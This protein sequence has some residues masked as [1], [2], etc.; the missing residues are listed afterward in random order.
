M[1]NELLRLKLKQRLNKL[2]SND[3]TNLECWQDAELL[4]KAAL[5]W[6]RRQLHGANA[7]GEGDEGSKR[8]I[9]DLQVLLVEKQLNFSNKDLYFE[10]ETIPD[11]YL[12]FKRIS[13]TAITNKCQ[14]P[15]KIRVTL[16][17]EADIDYILSDV[18][19]KPSF[20]WR[21]TVAT[22][23]GNKI[24]IWTNSEFIVKNVTLTYYR[25]PVKVAFDSC[26]D[27]DGSL[28]ENTQFEFKDAI[29][30]LII[31]EAVSIASG[32]IQDFNN[33]QRFEKSVE[34]NN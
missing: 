25:E 27:Y 28:M 18:L 7:F 15:Q 34:N 19:R 4:N 11:N 2:A 10:T 13:I 22:L 6:I 5:Q 31:D 20:E 14:T 24:K 33:Y 21:E 9:D 16:V 23:A 12:E 17:P 29:V 8:R 26:R 1:K 32:D 30:E 3:F